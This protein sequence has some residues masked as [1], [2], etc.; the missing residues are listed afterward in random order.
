MTPGEPLLST[1][2]PCISLR[3]VGKI[4]SAGKG[5]LVALSGVDLDIAAGQVTAIVGPSGSGK[6]TLLSIIGCILRPTSGEVLICSEGVSGLSETER[7]RIRLAHIGFVFQSYNLFPS[8]TARQNVEVALDLKGIRGRARSEQALSLLD[9]VELRDKAGAYPADLSGGQK[10]R[11]AIA[12]ALCGAPDIILA[13]EPTAALDS[14][15]G[16]RIMAVFRDLAR[17]AK[18]AVVIVTHDS[19]ILEF[20]DRVVSVDDGRVTEQEARRPAPAAAAALSATLI[21][22]PRS[23]ELAELGAAR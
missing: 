22:R 8:L 7:G 20:A 4:Y 17:S 14:V 23:F 19:R 2:A 10:Q 18:R 11:V 12:R 5:S 9:Q 6:T 16:R 15:T 21:R 1:A 13:D 3:G